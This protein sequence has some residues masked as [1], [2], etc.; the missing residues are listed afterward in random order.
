M[1]T[2][3]CYG[4][5]N[6]WGYDAKTARR[7]PREKRWTGILQQLLGEDYFIIEEGLCGRT[8][9]FSTAVEPEINGLSFLPVCLKSHAPLDMIVIMLGT[10]DLQL[11]YAAP[12]L[13]VARG[14]E[15]MV[16]IIR[17]PYSHGFGKVPQIL[18][19]S[20]TPA[21]EGI[22]RFVLRDLFGAA[23]C[24]P[25]TKELAQRIQSVAKI[26]DCLHLHAGA[27]AQP[28]TADGLHFDEDGH[29]A[30]AQAV[31]EVIR[32]KG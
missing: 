7:Y 22:A 29:L 10:N 23:D 18:L 15:K 4:D 19:I 14:I 31:A 24:I 5:S 21:G 3:L 8:A 28:C 25:R 12:P 2:I 9:A 1:Y 17:D 13:E 30:L 27:A 11:K 20:P 6:T 32:T 26:Y 16:Q